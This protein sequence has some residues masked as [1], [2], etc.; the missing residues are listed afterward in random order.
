MDQI[1]LSFKAT[2]SLH[3]SWSSF[4]DEVHRQVLIANAI[5]GD[6]VCDVTGMTRDQRLTLSLAVRYA[7]PNARLIVV[8]LCGHATSTPESSLALEKLLEQR[9]TERGEMGVPKR[10]FWICCC[11]LI[12]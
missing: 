4:A 11:V 9:I 2:R 5:G 7:A 3:F 1:L 12:V 10:A 6:L 8:N